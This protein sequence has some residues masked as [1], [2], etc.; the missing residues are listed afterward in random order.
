[1]PTIRI[2]M[3]QINPTVGAVKMNSAKILSYAERAR[4]AGADLVVFP[5]LALTGYPPE[6]LLLKPAFIKG[7]LDE[8]K[9][10]SRK[11]KGVAAVVGFVDRAR[12][13][14]PIHNAAAVVSGGRVAAVYHKTI[15]PNYGVFDEERYFEAGTQPLNVKVAGVTVGIG[16][17]EDIWH[18]SGPVR[19]EVRAGAGLIVNINASPF[20]IGKARERERVVRETAKRV[21]APVVFVNAVGGQDELVF[22]GRSF[23]V[24]RGGKVVSTGSAFEEDLIVTDVDVPHRKTQKGTGVK[25]VVVK[26]PARSGAKAA[27]QKAKRVKRLSQAEEVHRALLLG[28]RDYVVKN[29]FGRVV[30]A[31]SG[32]VDSA[33]VAAVAAEA[34]GSENVTALFMPSKY[35]SAASGQDAERLAGNLGID[36]MTVPIGKVFDAY[37]KTLAK[38]FKGLKADVTPGITE[39]NLQARTR[40]NLVMALSNKYGWLVLTTGNKSEMSVG[41]ATLYGDMAGGFAVIKDVPKTTVYEICKFINDRA[42]APVI[43]A[44]IITKAPTAELRPRQKDSDSLPPYHILDP[45]LKAYVEDDRSPE[46]IQKMGYGKAVIK[47]VVALVDGSEYKR[48]QAPPGIKITPRAFGRDR[49]MPIT[50]RH[51]KK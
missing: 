12:P 14:G 26:T 50:N 8:L 48:R 7:N 51:G 5:E 13:R 41:Y 27:L 21:K 35:S 28:T 32:G 24:D 16:I 30:V 10:V 42:G 33:L 4:R 23:I 6:D 18:R 31:L 9:R 46:E 20:H 22:D 38:P 11:I 17:C 43:P 45:I 3:A 2:A 37:L 40:G 1:M 34:L 25:K 47:K 29:G 44:R 19:A 39:E 15:L 49:R 36:F